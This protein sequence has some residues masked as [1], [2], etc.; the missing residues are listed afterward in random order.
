M[1]KL[2]KVFGILLVLV[3]AIL[4]VIPFFLEGKIDT[5]VRRTLDG[6]L[7]AKVDYHD[8]N[9]SLIKNFPSASVSIDELEIINNAPFE[10]DTLVYA[11]R[12]SAKISLID[13][14]KGIDQ[15]V[16]IDKIILDKAYVNVQV[17]KEG[18]ANYDITKGDS[19]ATTTDKGSEDS[20]S[21]F[22]INLDY[23][24]LD[25]KLVYNDVSSN[26]YAELSELS[27]SGK[28]D[29]SSSLID[30]T[31]ETVSRFTYKMGGIQYAE[32]MPI[33]LKAVIGID[34]ANNKYSFKDN[35]A[36][37][38]EIP[39]EF[40]GFIQLLEKGTDIELDFVSKGASFKN[41]LASIPNAYKEDYR[42]VTANG[43]FDLHGKING[44][45]SDHKIPLL[46]INLITENASFKYP[47]L[48]K[49]VKDIDIHI[50]VKNTT[51]NL[52]DTA[53][54]IKDFKFKIDQDE[55]LAS[56]KLWNLVKN[57][58]ADLNAKGRLDLG[59]LAEAYPMKLPEGLKGIIDADLASKFDLNSIQKGKY[60]RIKSKGEVNLNAF[61]VTDKSMP[62][63]IKIDNAKVNFSTN[64]IVLESLKLETGSSDV[65]GKGKLENLFPFIFADAEL[66][67]DFSLSSN[68]FVVQDFLTQS[69]EETTE[70]PKEEDSGAKKEGESTEG[71]IPD[72]LDITAT[73]A[74]KEVVYDKLNL[75]NAKGQVTIKDAKAIL[76]DVSSDVFG[77][78]IGFGGLVDT[79]KEI[80][81]FDMD[82]DMSKLD[83]AGS[84][85]SLE[86][87]QKFTPV[88][89]ALTGVFSSKIKLGGNLNNDLT[90][91]LNSLK[92]LANATIVKA[93]VNSSN[94]KLLSAFDGKANFIDLDKLNL[95]DITANFNFEDGKIKVK[96]FNFKLN[97]D[98]AVK[99]EGGHSFDAGLSYN[100]GLDVPAKYL[101][102]QAGSLLSS[103]SGSEL[104]TTKVS[105]PVNLGGTFKDPKV[106][107]DMKGAISNL[108]SSILQKQKNKVKG[109]AVSEINKRVGDK[110][111]DVLGGLL[112][113]NKSSSKT[114]AG[115][116]GVK[117][118]ETK[119]QAKDAAKSL[120]NNLF[121]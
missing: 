51:G 111:K 39:L 60:D 114:E 40:H 112:G 120:I 89:S 113:G 57:L 99:V 22:N 15:G 62:H 102:S 45:S 61:E 119:D 29:V 65:S 117:K 93:K 54:I 95:E 79:S 96:P 31:T 77:G 10:G 58:N 6:Q 49:E 30:L 12:I 103:L 115:D 105:I 63:P 104:E 21:P 53:V 33:D 34:Q 38:N 7:N 67:G 8:I 1:K 27:H 101:G 35:V 86:M 110:A 25:S 118:T 18:K 98:I 50:D 55:F 72:F 100:L 24:I 68:K 116:E 73:F 5:I 36:H 82:L 19:S 13:L 81:S 83:L 70:T 109:K 74:A 97:D 85:A 42:E 32:R 76:K 52:D 23:D 9:L 41:L 4:I 94:S 84:F 26:L 59:K 78:K 48:T 88:A 37:I 91:N 106:G 71:L 107:L 56:G 16:K 121:K 90:P 3:L 66:K 64:Q 43:L 92:G 20:S 75:K 14:I 87:L 46:D 17:N 80:P 11:D 44:I 108:S 69:D 28:G 2:I 47:D